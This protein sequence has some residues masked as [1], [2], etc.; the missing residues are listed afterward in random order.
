MST[1]EHETRYYH[2][3]ILNLGSRFYSMTKKTRTRRLGTVAGGMMKN[4]PG[5]TGISGT[6]RMGTIIGKPRTRMKLDTVM[7]NQDGG[8][9]EKSRI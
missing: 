7:E 3:E 8:M 1:R 6:S 4:R 2:R 9:I 5:M